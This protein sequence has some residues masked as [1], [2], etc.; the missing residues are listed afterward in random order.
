MPMLRDYKKR[1]LD[2]AK[3]PS[4]SAEDD[5]TI[6]SDDAKMPSLSA[7]DEATITSDDAEMSSL[8]LNLLNMSCF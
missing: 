7:H 6:T 2:D 5:T 1:K 3:M 8:T 4:L